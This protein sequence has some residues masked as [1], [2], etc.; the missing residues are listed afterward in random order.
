[1]LIVFGRLRGGRY[2]DPADAILLENE[3]GRLIDATEKAASFLRAFGM[4]T[5]A[6]IADIDGDGDDDML[7]VGEW[8][9]PTLLLQQPDGT[10]DTQSLSDPGRGLWWTV[11]T[12][13]MDGD[14]D[15]D[16]LL[17][18]LGWNNKFGGRG[19]VNLEV[20]AGDLDANGDFDVVLA[21]EKKDKV[22]P[23]RGRECSSQEL[24]FILD[25]FPTYDSFAKA[26]LSD[27]YP[28]D[29]LGPSSHFKLNTLSS[30]YL[31]T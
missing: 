28:P 11:E 8:L 31:E 14:G 19:P 2:G 18:N 12:G 7:V 26:G 27:I 9:A 15:A 1:D 24:P 21:V 5:D 25:K 16:F 17:G 13:D 30:I 22:L 6:A 23:V 3:N 20:Y 4:V 29:M 10:I